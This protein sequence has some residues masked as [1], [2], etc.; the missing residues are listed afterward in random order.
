MKKR[1][2]KDR[3]TCR[4]EAISIYE[5]HLGSWKKKEE[6]SDNGFYNY[7]E[8]AEELADYVVDMGYTHIEII[9]IAEHPFDGSW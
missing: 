1:Q 7:R 3:L 6:D 4:E 9:G 5:V 8:I 2:N